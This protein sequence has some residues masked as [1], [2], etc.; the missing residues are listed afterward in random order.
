MSTKAWSWG[1][2]RPS[3]TPKPLAIVAAA[4]LL[5]A[6]GGGDAPTGTGT[7][8][9]V[10]LGD[11]SP[12]TVAVG[13]T[14]PRSA[15]II[16]VSGTPGALQWSSDNTAVATVERIGSSSV[17]EVKGI[18]PGTA[19]IRATVGSTS[20]A[21][22]V[23]VRSL[24]FDRLVLNGGRHACAQTADGT[25][26]CWGDHGEHA[27]GPIS[28]PEI[29][30]A[31]IRQCGTTPRLL[32]TLPSFVKIAVSHGGITCGL[33]ADGSAYCWGNNL[34]DIVAPSSISETCIPTQVNPFSCIS[35][36][37]P[38]RG[39]VK[40]A[41]LSL[42][43]SLCG[44]TVDGAAYCWGANDFGQV[45]DGTLTLRTTPTPV[46]GGLTF[47]SLSVGGWHA[48]G[49]TVGGAAYC[50][51][52]NGV[53]QL[54]DGTTAN[55]TSPVAVAGGLTFVGLAPA[56]EYTCGVT[57][58]GAVYCWGDNTLGILG[59]GTTTGSL[60]PKKIASTETFVSVTAGLEH[61]CALTTGQRARCW[62]QNNGPQV[63]GQLGDGTKTSSL[64]PVAVAR[65]L[66]FV[67]LRAGR[68]FTCGRTAEG[69]IY[70]WGDNRFG[71]LG[72][73]ALTMLNSP[74][75]VGVAGVP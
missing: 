74:T 68:A 27:L 11:L 3:P 31:Q 51:G 10:T 66:A 47:A 21:T 38:V 13:G 37:T 58:T 54:G 59:D 49:L 2:A 61:A 50:W 46:I 6:C 73:G 23:T 39:S 72:A 44:L 9:V 36:P 40:F 69:K 41:S 5:C 42:G 18:A 16:V 25:T 34:S 30:P 12:V 55:R 7:E 17:G 29:C 14:V 48:C 75:P 56:R 15:A 8:G 4:A 20:V 26:F 1:T 52:A 33:T 71:Q 64:A 35:T 22:T 63:Q 67:E 53:G 65:D 19:T 32:T 57:S 62:G 45:G 24:A 43:G 28:D 70:C 60:V